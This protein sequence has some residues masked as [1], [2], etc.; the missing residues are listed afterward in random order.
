VGTRPGLA[1]EKED[2]RLKLSTPMAALLLLAGCAAGQKTGGHTEA[3]ES[4]V[5]ALPLEDVLPQATALLSQQ[6]WRV[7]R[8]G[9]QLGT[10]WRIDSSGAALGYRVEGTRVDEAHSSIQFELLAATS[11]APPP[12]PGSTSP[13]ANLSGTPMYARDSSGGSGASGGRSTGWDGV[14][15]PT[16]LG[17]APPGLVTLP[18]GRD[19]GLEW[20]LLQRLDPRA[21][22]AIAHAE[23]RRTSA[24][25]SRAAV[26][27]AAQAPRPAPPGCAPEPTGLEGPEAERRLIL[28]ADIPGTNEIPEFVG[29]LAC[30]ATR[31]GLPTV[32]ALGLYRLDQDLVDTYFASQGTA[33]DRAA[34]LQVA[35]SFDAQ[36]SGVRGSAAVL[37]LLDM[38]RVLRDT[39]L[40]LRLVAFDEAGS[41]PQRNRA[42][43]TTLERVRRT[44]PE[45]LLL[46][47]L[48]RAEAQTIL[49]SGAA[50]SQAPVGWFLA[51]WAL[52]P[53]ALDVH[54]QGGQAWSCPPVQG[55]C[56]PVSV[57]TAAAAAHKDAASVELYGAQD[58]Q[59]FEGAYSV[60]LVTAAA[61]PH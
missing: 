15:A 49:P 23:A 38:L 6:G 40:P 52:R 1:K 53:L 50:P 61:P 44:Q 18:R 29:R 58:A 47:V 9:D 56:T 11:F 43:A 24:A 36:S 55:K 48:E 25:A 45:A 26:P 20:A 57:P 41:P 12:P 5:Y 39:G 30:Q 37:R 19:D 27:G 14:D 28:L 8:S 51:H 34:F 46:V 59:G 31:K 35:R 54:T 4:H 22:Q 7:E 33:E 17:E 60:G 13:S 16:T 2:S 21:A 3:I 10:N 32:V 42:V